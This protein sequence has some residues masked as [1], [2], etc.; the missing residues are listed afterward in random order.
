MAW[1]PVRVSPALRE[2]VERLERSLLDHDAVRTQE[3]AQTISDEVCTALSV[4][5]VR[6]LVRDVRPSNER[7]ELHGLYVPGPGKY[8]RINLWMIT[9]KRG[10]VVAYKTFLRTLL[11][12]ICHHLDY[13]LLGLRESFHT[14]GF[15]KRESSLFHQLTR[16]SAA[17]P[18]AD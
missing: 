2:A 6:V 3:L 8:D 18:G 10:R 12:E 13:E 17:V 7:G 1:I 16:P 14:D 11:H 15:F 9:A 5:T 4:G